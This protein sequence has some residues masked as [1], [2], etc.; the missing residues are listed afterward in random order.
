MD[1]EQKLEKIR[2]DGSSPESIQLPEL[3]SSRLSSLV[4]SELT[5]MQSSP[6]GA[7]AG[8]PARSQ[9]LL[10]L[11]GVGKTVLLNRIGSLS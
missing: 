2:Q 11:R 1:Q 8:R 3:A 7:R 4:V 10:G 5:M 9:F 6:C